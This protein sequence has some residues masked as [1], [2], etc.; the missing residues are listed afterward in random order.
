MARIDDDAGEAG[1]RAGVNDYDAYA[2]AY[3]AENETSLVNA[4]TSGPRCW[5]SPAT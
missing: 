5:P 2:E 3:A 1:A 4:P